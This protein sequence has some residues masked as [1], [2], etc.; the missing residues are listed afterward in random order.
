VS[1]SD[2]ARLLTADDAA[3]VA[4]VSR[5]TLRDWTRRGLLPRYGTARRVLYDWRDLAT[6][7]DAGKPRRVTG[8]VA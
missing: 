4:G 6:A 1:R 8:R 5:A 7:K 3:Q 2:R